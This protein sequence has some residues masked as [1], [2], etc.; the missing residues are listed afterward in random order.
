MPAAGVE[1]EG[2]IH[3]E[4]LTLKVNGSRNTVKCKH[5]D[6]GGKKGICANAKRCSDHL[7]EAHQ[8][9]VA[10]SGPPTAPEVEDIDSGDESP[11]ASQVGSIRAAS[12]SSQS[13]GCV[14]R[15]LAC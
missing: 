11:P 4:A 1:W 10:L 15:R 6:W 14:W 7:K 3:Y 13:P 5:C 9:L 2:W 12:S 8:N